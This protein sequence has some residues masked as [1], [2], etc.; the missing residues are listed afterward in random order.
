M[1]AETPETSPTFDTADTP[2]IAATSA[3]SGRF[4]RLWSASTATNLGDGMRLVALP[5]LAINVTTDVRQIALVTVATFAPLLLLGPFA[6]VLIDRTDR[7]TAI[8]LSHLGRAVLLLGL[9]ALI[10]ADRATLGWVITA[11]VLYGIGEA[12]ADPAS[13][14]YLPQLMPPDQL[15]T[16]NSRLMVGQ[17]IADQFLGRALGGLLFA[18]SQLLP[19]TANAAVLLVAAA[20][21]HDLREGWHTLISSP[22][23]RGLTV[24]IAMWGIAA[25][26][27]WGIG[28]V[29]ALDELNSGDAGFGIMVALSAGGSLIGAAITTPLVERIGIFPTMAATIAI[30]VAAVATMSVANHVLVAAGLLALNSAA[31]FCWIILVTTIRQVVVPGHLLG[32][33]AAADRMLYALT[34][35][36]AAALAGLLA[37]AVGT[38]LTLL[39]SAIPI[40]LA[41]LLLPPLRRPLTDAWART[42]QPSVPPAR[43]IADCSDRTRSRR[44]R[45]TPNGGS[46][47][48][49]SGP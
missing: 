34:F 3:S 11:A 15:A 31:V 16:A 8:A 9:A 24:I 27:F 22:L 17:V 46:G 39:I 12:I 41:A 10:A 1:A 45:F 6:G 40:L 47:P 36:S 28:V 14:A 25:G 32:R 4:W 18:V 7:R 49:R 33:V 30:S 29:Y 42:H 2:N 20:L 48:S 43:S 44:A 26:T 13:Q 5:L 19:F 35:P 23:L 38:R 21:L 37:A